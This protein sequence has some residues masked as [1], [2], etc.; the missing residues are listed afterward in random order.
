M[1]WPVSGIEG[2]ISP[3]TNGAQGRM[4]KQ[5]QAVVCPYGHRFLT[6]VLTT[7]R[8][9]NRAYLCRPELTA[10]PSFPVYLFILSQGLGYPQ[11]A[12]NSVCS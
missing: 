11:L 4:E 3:W 5:G 7:P 8:P 10:L 9:L 1:R 2:L 6:K 12:L